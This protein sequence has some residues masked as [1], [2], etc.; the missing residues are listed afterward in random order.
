MKHENQL[1]FVSYGNLKTNASVEV[2]KCLGFLL[3]FYEVDDQ[4]KLLLIKQE[5]KIS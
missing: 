5:Y 3:P 2:T 4:F 1:V